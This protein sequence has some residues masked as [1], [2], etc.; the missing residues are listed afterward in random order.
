M[1]S[2]FG[3]QNSAISG[4]FRRAGT[5]AWVIDTGQP[6]PASIWLTSMNPAA[7][8]TLAPGP[9]CAQAEVCSPWFTENPMMRW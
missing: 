6:W 1:D 4:D 8:S 9:G 3:S 7:R 2:S 5:T